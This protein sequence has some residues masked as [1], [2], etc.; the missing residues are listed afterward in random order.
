[1]SWLPRRLSQ[2]IAEHAQ[3]DLQ[4][5]QQQQRQQGRRHAHRPALAAP[6]HHTMADLYGAVAQ[7]YD[8]PWLSFR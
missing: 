8:T 1:V 7:Y 4:Q 3:Q 2:Q 6:F 5:Q